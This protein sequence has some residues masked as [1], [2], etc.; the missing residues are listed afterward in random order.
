[1]IKQLISYFSFSKKEL[2]GILVLLFLVFLILS[3]PFCYRILDE[4]E[5]YDLIQFQKEIASFKA[6]AIIGRRNHPF[7]RER[8]DERVFDPDYFKFDP[9]TASP[10]DWQKLGLSQK[11]IK[12]V[13]NYLS[14]G[15]KFYRS[16]DLRKI[17][18][19][20]EQQYR[21][22]EPYIQIVQNKTYVSKERVQQSKKEYAK[23]PEN[24]AIQVELNL[25]DSAMFDQL[26][27]IGPVFASRII[28]FRNRLGGFYKKE[29]LMEVYGMDSLRYAQLEKQIVVD[30]SSIKKLNINTATF[31]EVR[32]HP[33][34]NF[35]QIN[36]II[37]Y[38]KQHG[39]YASADD[40]KKVLI[41][42]E[43]IIRKIEPYLSFDP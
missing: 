20:T 38:R 1:M 24:N 28:R 13:R 37:Q 21:G 18:S 9:N 32:S 19:I 40:L 12:V 34:L 16:E 27:G 43:E 15:G 26:R 14:K 6:S 41:L 33:Y 17:Y 36:A 31:D 10:S 25:A 22:L 7:L 2:N 11:Q 23:R 4:P 30:A 5:Q 42:N 3:V 8:I 39:I 29:Q 35:K